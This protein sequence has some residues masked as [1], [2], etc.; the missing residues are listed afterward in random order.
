[1]KCNNCGNI[2]PE[3]TKFCTHCGTKLEPANLCPRCGSA[4]VPSAKFCQTC[5]T[6]LKK[7]TS[8]RPASG[9][10]PSSAPATIYSII[11]GC[12]SIAFI[13]LLLNCFVE[14]K[15]TVKLTEELDTYYE[16]EFSDFPFGFIYEWGASEYGYDDIHSYYI[17]TVS[18]WLLAFAAIVA[19]SLVGL[20]LNLKKRNR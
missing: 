17:K 19:G 9:S 11:L 3:G 13:Y 18:I 8:T 20:I 12:A 4:T 10:K 5:G 6:P 16:Y 1:M 2:C 14:P 15:V 7:E